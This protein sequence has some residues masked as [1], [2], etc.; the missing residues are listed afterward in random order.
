M[1]LWM[2]AIIA[3]SYTTVTLGLPQGTV[4]APLLFIVSKNIVYMMEQCIAN[5]WD[6]LYEQQK[7]I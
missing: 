5:V 4:L 2:D 7:N 1:W 6:Y 3:N